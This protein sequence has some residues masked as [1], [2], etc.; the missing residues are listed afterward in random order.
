MPQANE[1]ASCHSRRTSCC[2]YRDEARRELCRLESGTSAVPV[3]RPSAKLC[4]LRLVASRKRIEPPTRG[5]SGREIRIH[6]R[7]IHYCLNAGPAA[8]LVTLAA[9]QLH[10]ESSASME[11]G[12]IGARLL[13]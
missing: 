10:S 12:P 1:S 2:E 7:R 5:C 8:R 6:P 13:F 9:V 4:S 3:S 11:L